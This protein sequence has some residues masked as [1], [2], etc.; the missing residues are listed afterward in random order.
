MS[1]RRRLNKKRVLQTAAQL[2]EESGGVG[3]LT[4]TAL[5]NALGVQTPSLYNHIDG[6]E[7]LREELTLLAGRTL[8]QEVRQ[9]A[10]GRTGVEALR[11]MGH[12]Y[13]AFAHNHPAL[14]PLTTEA[15]D[16]E[17]TERVA[18][19]QEWLQ[20][21]LLTMASLGLHDDE[22]LHAIRTYRALLHGFVS[23]EASGGFKMDLDRDQSFEMMLAAFLET[24]ARSRAAPV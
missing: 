5:A 18:L 2:A 12:A 21:L 15:P 16:P 1:R 10:Y 9:A 22:A 24:V 23:L 14:Y 8:L 6:L 3:E 20:M 11:S 17:E 4:L 7:G 13:R 19:A